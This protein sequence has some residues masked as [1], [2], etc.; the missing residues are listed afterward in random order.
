MAAF[1]LS[2]TIH[3]DIKRSYA[4][5]NSPTIAAM[6]PYNQRGERLMANGPEEGDL[7]GFVKT[8]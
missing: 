8:R 2:G 3:E 5:W 4:M 1:H 7:S 6:E